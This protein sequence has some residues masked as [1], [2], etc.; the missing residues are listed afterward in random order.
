MRMVKCQIRVWMP[1]KRIERNAFL[2]KPFKRI[3]TS[4]NGVLAN[5]S[6]AV[7][8]RLVP[9]RATHH[10][11]I[12]ALL[13]KYVKTKNNIFPHA[14][15]LPANWLKIMVSGN[16]H[17]MNA[18]FLIGIHSMQDWTTTARRGI[19][20]KRSLKRLGYTGKLFRKNL[21]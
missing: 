14:T 3:L 12:E 13:L 8:K 5:H 19:T 18:I 11:E 1:C 4:W 7:F 9:N 21:R 17:F 2:T 16:W 20:R 10:Q 6:N 15:K